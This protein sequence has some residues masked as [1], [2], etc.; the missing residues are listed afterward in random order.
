MF[1][2]KYADILPLAVRELMP[3]FTRL[4]ASIGGDFVRHIP[5]L[6]EV[7][8]DTLGK[9]HIRACPSEGH[10]AAFRIVQRG[11]VHVE[12]SSFQAAI[13]IRGRPETFRRVLG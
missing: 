10:Q 3:A 13:D 7:C 1:W 12:L 8:S 9:H 4:L 5:D 6:R 2:D 11:A